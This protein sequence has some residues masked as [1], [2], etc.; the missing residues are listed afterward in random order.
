MRAG[1]VL[2]ACKSF[3]FL[4]RLSGLLKTKLSEFQLNLGG[5]GGGV[6]GGEGVIIPTQIGSVDD[7]FLLLLLTSYVT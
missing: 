5:G 6:G 7:G 1:F 2:L 4:K 3:I